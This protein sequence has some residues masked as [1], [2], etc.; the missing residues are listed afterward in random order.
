M[1]TPGSDVAQEDQGGS[2]KILWIRIAL[3]AAMLLV[4]VLRI[5]DFDWRKLIPDPDA[6]TLVWLVGSCCLTLVA[7]GLATLRW[8]TVLSAMGLRH[9]FRALLGYYLAG[10]FVSNVLPTTIGGDVLRV[11]RASQD[12][13]DS[14]G[15]FA[16][17]VIERLTGWI[18]LPAIT[19]LGLALNPGLRNLG[20]ATLVATSIAGVTLVGLVLILFAVDHR[21]IGGRFADKDGWQR[22][23]G[24]VH[25]GIGRLRRRPLM[26]GSVIGVGL[27]YQ[28]TL[29]VAAYMAAHAMG[30]DQA[31]ITALMVFLPAVLIL[32]VLPISISGFGVREGALILFLSHSALGVPQESAIG[33]GILL[34]LLNAAVSALG[35]PALAVGRGGRRQATTA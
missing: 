33:L 34:Y 4:L 30:I 35:A 13:G 28:L 3:S 25:L 22:F 18:V 15:S 10:Q 9:G 6:A 29:V 17:V 2:R 20:Q 5:P 21:R 8:Q 27:A 14:P 11:A 16:S 7:V 31:G 19:L 32:Q 26:A 23:A 12:N 1:T 24:A